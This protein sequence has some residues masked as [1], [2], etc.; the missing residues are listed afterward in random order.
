MQRG[1]LAMALAVHCKIEGGVIMQLAG[2]SPRYASRELAYLGI[3]SPGSEQQTMTGAEF[4]SIMSKAQ[5][6]LL[7]QEYEATQAKAAAEGK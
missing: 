1:T 4:M 7:L 6:Y 5:D 2:P 3:L